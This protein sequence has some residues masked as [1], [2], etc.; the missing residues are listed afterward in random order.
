MP[1]NRCYWLNQSVWHAA[2]LNRS[3]RCTCVERGGR[4]DHNH[5]GNV[6]SGP[7]TRDPQQS[8]IITC[9]ERSGIDIWCYATLLWLMC[10]C[11]AE[12]M[13]RSRRCTAVEWGR[14]GDHSHGLGQ[15]SEWTQ[16]PWP[17][18]K[19][20]HHAWVTLASTLYVYMHIGCQTHSL[21]P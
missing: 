5:W 2:G 16:D 17:S 19:Q 18:T 4:E 3:R 11:I 14:R 13:D 8:R 15:R 21:V 6:L 10:V 12:G 9:F 1:S 7:E 20:R